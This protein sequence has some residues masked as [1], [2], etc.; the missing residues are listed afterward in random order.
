MTGTRID[1]KT[2]RDMDRINGEGS[3]RSFW[4]VLMD[5]NNRSEFVE[6]LHISVG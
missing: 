6:A 5:N 4:N 3:A 1:V 2:R